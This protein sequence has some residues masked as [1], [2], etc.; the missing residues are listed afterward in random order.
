[1]PEEPMI[2]SSSPPQEFGREAIIE[3]PKMDSSE[4]Y[5]YDSKNRKFIKYEAPEPVL[6]N[7]HSNC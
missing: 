1:M 6:K 5:I 3:T 2:E 7:E 4:Q